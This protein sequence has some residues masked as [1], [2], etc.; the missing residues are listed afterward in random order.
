MSKLVADHILERLEAWGVRR[1]YG[2]PGDGINGIV[3]ALDRAQDSLEFVQ[4]RH[5]EMAAFMACGHAKF[6]GEVGVCLATSGPGAIHLL[7]GLYDAKL[8]HQ[9]VVAIVGQQA[10]AAMGGHYQQEV[11]LQSLFKDVAG[12]YVQTASTAAQI[13][14]LIDRAVRIARTRADG[15][16]RDRPQRSAAGGGGRDAAAAHGTVHSGL[17]YSAPR[18][19]PHE[20]DLA[21]AAEILNAGERVAILVGAG[22]LRAGAEVARGRRAA[23]RRRR[24]GAARQGGAAGRAA[25]GDRVDRPARHEAELGSDAGVRHAADGRVELP[26]LGVP[27]RGGAGA[28]RADRH[29]RPHARDPLSDGGQP[30]RRRG[31]DAAGADPAARRARRIAAGASR[32]RR[33]SRRGGG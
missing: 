28:R 13:R 5:E 12:E 14:H 8:D 17:G 25:V 1:I 22:A 4:V 9:P 31:R 18:V 33:T 30:R 11:D 23:R 7:N 15:H 29:R 6:T 19:V 32:S 26:L 16:V 2:Y 3:G 10:R 20:D 24:E 27:A 21:R